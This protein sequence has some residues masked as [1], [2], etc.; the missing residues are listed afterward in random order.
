M[1]EYEK[2]YISEGIDVN[3]S[4]NSKE[5]SIYHY[6]FFLDKNFK[7]NPYLCNG[8][9][10]MMMKVISFKNVAIIYSKGNA[11]RV[12]FSSMTKNDTINLI[13]NSNLSNKGVLL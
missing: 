8:C 7:Y 12:M 2:I 6:W 5:C 3:K 9:S 11:Y 10:D 13:K 1:L 4:S